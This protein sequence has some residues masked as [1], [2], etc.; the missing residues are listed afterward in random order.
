VHTL[1]ESLQQALNISPEQCRSL[2]KKFAAQMDPK[3]HLS[4]VAECLVEDELRTGETTELKR[5][6]VLR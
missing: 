2:Y 4:Y 1:R 5:S 3:H 6:S